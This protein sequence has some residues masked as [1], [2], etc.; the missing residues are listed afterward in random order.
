MLVVLICVSFHWVFSAPILFNKFIAVYL[1]GRVGAY[2][3]EWVVGKCVT[4]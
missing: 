2:K 1:A 3:G 4:E